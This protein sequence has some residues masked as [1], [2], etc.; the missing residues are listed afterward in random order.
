M[1][2]RL[3]SGQTLLDHLS[4]DVGHQIH[5]LLEMRNVVLLGAFSLDVLLDG[6]DLGLVGYQSLLLFVEAVVDVALQNLVLTRV[7]LHRVEGRLLAQAH[8]IVADHLL[9]GRELSFLFLE[10]LVELVCLRELVLDFVFHFLNTGIVLLE[11]SLD[12]SAQVLVL[13]QVLFL[14]LDLN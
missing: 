4:V 12:G 5:R 9:D 3:A 14:G 10:L 1:R 2:E 8:L 13:G 11:L 6:V 7:V